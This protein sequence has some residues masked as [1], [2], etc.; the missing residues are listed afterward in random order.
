M[1]TAVVGGSTHFTATSVSAAS[2]QASAKP[3][4]IH[5]R[6]LRTVTFRRG[7][8]SCG[9]GLTVTLQDNP[10][11]RKSSH[12]HTASRPAFLILRHLPR[13][14]ITRPRSWKS[15]PH[16]TMREPAVLPSLDV[17]FRQTVHAGPMDCSF[18]LGLC[19]AVSRLVALANLCSL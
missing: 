9:F 3:M 10:A 14:P 2:D 8:L 7:C 5:R 19:G 1:W 11:L 18:S 4:P 16:P 6:T 15:A 12:S 17:Q 13:S